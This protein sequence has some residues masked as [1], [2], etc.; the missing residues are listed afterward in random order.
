MSAVPAIARVYVANSGTQ[1]LSV[2]ALA[3]GGALVNLGAVAIQQPA[4]TG[5]SVVLALSP[6]AKFLYA[7]YAS[8][9]EQPR[10]ATFSLAPAQPLPLRLADTPLAESVAYLATDR[11]GR[12]LLGASYAGNQVIV[13]AIDANGV[14]AGVR[15]VVTTES[16]AHCILADPANRHVLHTSLGGD[17]VYQQLFDAGS[18]R[19]T[20]NAPPSVPVRAKSGPRF[21]CFA[22]NAR[23][24]YLIGELDG[25]ITV[26][27]FDRDRGVL[28]EPLQTTSAPPPD[29]AGTIWAADLHVRPDGRFLYVCERTSST[30][31]AF[32]IDPDSGALTRLASYTTVKQPRAF[33]IDP[34]GRFLVCSGQLANAVIVYA[35][36]PELG[37]LTPLAQYPVGGNPTWVSIVAPG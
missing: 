19:L 18:G 27:P 5:R 22:P 31:S 21:L 36:H 30:L 32:G 14:V 8:G 4:V 34:D 12:F 1:D 2:F 37:T 11:S 17:L 7:G 35:I 25:S 24:V 6:D 13:H 15:Q 26:F 33:D 28:G 16:K 9:P 3:A 10:V 23:V 29:F 20:P